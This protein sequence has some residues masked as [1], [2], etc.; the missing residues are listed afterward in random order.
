M[1]VYEN[2]ND[3]SPMYSLLS[4]CD[5]EIVNLLLFRGDYQMTSINNNN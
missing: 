2:C 3:V 4:T 1:R 5:I